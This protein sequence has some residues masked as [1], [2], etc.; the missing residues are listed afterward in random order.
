M[1]AVGAAGTAVGAGT[2]GCASEGATRGA[3]TGST[4]APTDDSDS[5]GAAGSGITAGGLA[6]ETGSS[7]TAEVAFGVP[8]VGREAGS[9][10]DGAESTIDGVGS[11][12]DRGVVTLPGAVLEIAVAPAGGV[13]RFAT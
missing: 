3:T 7:A 13:R 4:A 5:A 6:T 2:E 8:A 10:V 11:G 9:P 12:F 1:A